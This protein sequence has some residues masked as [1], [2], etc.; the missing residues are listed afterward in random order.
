M[1]TLETDRIRLMPWHFADFAAFRPI[2]TDPDVMRYIHNGV[3]WNDDQIREFVRRQMRHAAA[4][5]FCLWRIVRKPDGKMLGFCGLQLLKIEGQRDVE[6]GW[7]LA[8]TCWR[9]GIATEAARAAMRFAFDKAKLRRVIAIA[10]PENDASVRIMRKLG[11]RFE[12]DGTHK[13]IHVVFYSIRRY[14]GS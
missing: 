12:C 13:G 8:K 14:A 1:I 6:I 5:Q 2:A 9:R 4:N 7:W 10:Q 3:P 11:M